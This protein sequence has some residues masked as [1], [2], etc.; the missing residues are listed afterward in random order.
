MN[1]RTLRTFCAALFVAYLILLVR[2]IVLKYPP[3]MTGEILRIWSVDG[4]IRHLRTA[5]VVPFHT[6]RRVLFH[7]RSPFETRTLVYN[8]IAFVPLGVF[9]PCLW[10]QARR[11]YAVLAAGVMVSLALELV[12]LITLLGEADVDDLLLNAAGALVGYGLF[13]TTATLLQRRP[14]A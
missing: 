9:L 6:I 1:T 3:R 10:K 13:R 11:W 5:N 14:A 4:F 7:T 8:V 2:L 12:Q